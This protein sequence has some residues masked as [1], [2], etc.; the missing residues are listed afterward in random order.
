MRSLLKRMLTEKD[1]EIVA[2]YSGNTK[3]E[4]GED[5]HRIMW[6]VTTPR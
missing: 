4:F 2:T 3:E 5:E 6:F 1:F